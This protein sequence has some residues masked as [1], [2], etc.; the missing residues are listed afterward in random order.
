MNV[1][2]GRDI[3]ESLRIAIQRS[4]QLAVD[5]R[6][7]AKSEA[8]L[9]TAD[10]Q[11][12]TVPLKKSLKN[13]YLDH[14]KPVFLIFD[15][16]EELFIFGSKQEK[17][18]FVKSVKT[19]VES[20][21]QVRFMFVIREEY[22][23]GI[24]EFERQIPTILSNRV[25]IEKMTRVNAQQAIE[26]PCKYAGIEVE[27]G[28]SEQLLDRLTPE[29][30]DVELTYLQVFLDKIY[31]LAVAE[32]SGKTPKFNFTLLQ[33]T[34]DVKDLLGSFL[35]EQISQLPDPDSALVVLKSFVSSKGTKRQV[36]E[37]DVLDY[38]RTL[39]K[40][41]SIEPLRELILRFVSLRILRDKDDSGRFELRHDALASKIYEKI[42]LV[43]KELLE[44][45]QFIENA[46][47]NYK[48]RKVML[49]ASDLSYIAPYED[50][51]F[52]GE[53]L[54][55]FVS[56]SKY[57]QQRARR[58]KR[59]LATAAVIALL[60]IMTGFTWWAMRERSKADEQRIEA[61]KQ[62]NEALAANQK[63][64]QANK[65]A[66]DA[67][68]KAELAKTEALN[69]KQRAE[70]SAVFSLQMKK[71]AELSRNDAI[72]AKNIAVLEL[73]SSMKKSLA[74]ELPKMNVI[75]IGVDN[76]LFISASGINPDKFII[77]VI[78][79]DGEIRYY[80]DK[81]IDNKFD[82]PE[83]V[84]KVRTTKKMIIN[85]KG[86][87]T[88]GDTIDFGN[89]QFRVRRI[90]DPVPKVADMMGGTIKKSELLN[91]DSISV[92]LPG[93]VY[94]LHLL[95]LVLH[96]LLSLKGMSVPDHHQIINILK[97]RKI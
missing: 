21:L 52:L 90:P 51:M 46:Y 67:K 49:S 82:Y 45:R 60:V 88:K 53:A 1:R 25:R 65:N 47:D 94:D 13:L 11:L 58:R 56:D 87:T 64:I 29:G 77:K 16:F 57:E 26:G 95:L 19:I 89:K 2:R 18:E 75:Y 24:T 63:A 37:E 50:K 61:E 44:V 84:I 96:F 27:Q 81:D 35:E 59:N 40:N 3:N 38:S 43:E 7:S 80:S 79:G 74:T 41:I 10:C 54:S 85:I 15:Q 33:Q 14:F 76:P 30:T 91:E 55:N 71:Q 20:D 86:I 66:L 72:N 42:T 4:Q 5:S 83:Y 28:F 97:S 32:S 62:K 12:P 73:Y 34:G 8:S 23:A 92:D 36:T 70:Q 48:R 68:D 17:E 22:L 31:K 39:G 78:E 93:F 6:Q 9:P 69:E